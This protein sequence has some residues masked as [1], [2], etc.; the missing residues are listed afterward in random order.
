MIIKEKL[1]MAIDK[2]PYTTKAIFY[3]GILH[4]KYPDGYYG[5][6]I[7]E[8]VDVKFGRNAIASIDIINSNG[9][10]M[11]Q[12]YSKFLI[13]D[14]EDNYPVVIPVGESNTEYLIILN[15]ANLSPIEKASRTVIPI[16]YRPVIHAEQ[17]KDSNENTEYLAMLNILNL[18]SL[19]GYSLLGLI[20][21][22]L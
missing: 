16:P 19:G 20:P 12:Y 3:T 18:N 2:I 1:T 11:Y 17:M 7:R 10:M 6:G 5:L 9:S 8:S 22:P 4:N 21:V 14:T 15:K 13:N